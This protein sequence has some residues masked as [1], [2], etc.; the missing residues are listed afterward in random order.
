MVEMDF[1][2]IDF[3]PK[4]LRLVGVQVSSEGG[5]NLQE[6]SNYPVEPEWKG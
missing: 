2:C 1:E 3:S 4:I 6:A 5:L